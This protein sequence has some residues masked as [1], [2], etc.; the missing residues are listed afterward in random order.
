MIKQFFIL[1]SVAQERVFVQHHTTTGFFAAMSLK[2]RARG[3]A[4]AEFA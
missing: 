2:L 3:V 1:I 4:E